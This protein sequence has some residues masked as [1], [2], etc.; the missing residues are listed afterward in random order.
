LLCYRG[1]LN[2]GVNCVA[3]RVFVPAVECK[4]ITRQERVQ[5]RHFRIRKKVCLLSG[6]TGQAALLAPCQAAQAEHLS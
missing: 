3:G 6:S 1:Q 4:A 2:L 5:K